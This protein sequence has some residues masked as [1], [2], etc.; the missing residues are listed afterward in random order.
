MLIWPQAA[1]IK[2][3]S[4]DIGLVVEKSGIFKCSD[5]GRK[6]DGYRERGEGGGGDCGSGEGLDHVLV[7]P[8]SEHNNAAIFQTQN[9]HLIF[10]CPYFQD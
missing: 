10:R 1:A 7:L 2:Q 5:G 6:V 3:M 8:Q 4:P 9:I